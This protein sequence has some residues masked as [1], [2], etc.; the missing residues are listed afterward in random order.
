MNSS[1]QTHILYV[2][3]YTEIVAGDFGG[4]G[5]GISCFEFDASTGELKLLNNQF[6]VNPS[7]LSIASI[8]H[9]SN[10]EPENKSSTYLF[11]VSE[12][13][14]SKKPVI[15]SYTI[16]DN[17]SLSLINTQTIEGGCPCHIHYF[18]NAEGQ[19][20]TASA[21]YETGNLVIHNVDNIHHENNNTISN[22][23]IHEPLN[24][25]HKGNSQHPSRQTSAHTHCA[26]FDIQSNK[27]LVCD[28]GLD[29]VKVYSVQK[30]NSIDNKTANNIEFEVVEEQIILLPAGSGPRHLCFDDNYSYGFIIN[31]LTGAITIIKHSAE[32]KEYEIK[33][34]FDA[35]G[36]LS[37]SLKESV[38]TSTSIDTDLGGAAI[39]V[40]A[41][42]RFV[43]TSMRSDNTIRLFAFDP[44]A[45]SLSFIASY[46]TEGRT[47]R[48]FTLDAS[49]KWLLVAHQDSD[50]ITIFNVNSYNG[51]LSYHKTVE[52]IESPVCLAWLP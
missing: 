9:S 46:P 31:E 22:S 26:Y 28:L 41:D 52:N 35:S 24:I 20:F 51:I 5:E 47:P 8:L 42:G 10:M 36:Q 4:H 32:K 37:D 27:L 44:I 13:L 49:G 39:R 3:S 40:S 45:E 18:K 23:N 14:A 19:S 43:Y 29:Q 1:I 15:H 11:A 38:N 2:G 12:I 25:Y 48:D 30:N 33:G 34:N 16:N 17:Y 21:C 7:Y 6:Q 50:T